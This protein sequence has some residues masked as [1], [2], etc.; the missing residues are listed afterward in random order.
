MLTLTM[1]SVLTRCLGFLYKIYLAK[2]MTTT[3][4]GIYNITLSV[5]MVLI[6]LVGSS[7]PL[8]ISKITSTNKILSKEKNTYYSVTSSLVL[9]S[10][11]SIFI[12]LIIIISKPI[13]TLII[14]GELGYHI[15]ITL[16]PSIIFTA[17]YSQIRGY[18]WGQENYFAV[19]IVEF[20]EQILRIL[21]CIIL[22]G[23]K[24]FKSPALAVGTALSIACGL[25]TLYGIIL[26]FKNGG[27]FQSY[28]R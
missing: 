6:T 12:S 5:Y 18:L 17:I 26:Y 22:I 1:F 15:V 11:L 8:T 21:F 24:I 13:L 9:T 19:S 23:F 4:L 14:G 27:K 20:I 3:E 2:I 7:I 28:H 25:S 16:I 10:L